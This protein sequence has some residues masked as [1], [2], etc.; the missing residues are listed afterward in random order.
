M[1]SAF[2]THRWFSRCST[3]WV[4][5]S[6]CQLALG[7]IRNRD[8]ALTKAAH[9]HAQRK[10][11]GRRQPSPFREDR[12][13]P[14][15]SSVAVYFHHWFTLSILSDKGGGGGRLVLPG[16]WEDT[17][18]LVVTCQPVDSGL[19]EN[20]AELG[21]LVLPVALQVLADGDSLLDKEVDVLWKVGSQT[22]PLQDTEDLVASHETDLGN[23]MRIPED[24]TNLQGKQEI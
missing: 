19:D 2:Q 23:T 13:Q 4:R 3:W 7:E 15:V 12:K 10:A 22:L 24:H 5:R 17:L 1:S 21:V 14:P 6:A 11:L 18:A 16:G 8:G 20:E 9:P